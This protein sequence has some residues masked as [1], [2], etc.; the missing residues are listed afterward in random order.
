M[1]DQARS[2]PR[3]GAPF[4]ANNAWSGWGYEW[5][6]KTSV[7]G[8]PLVHVAV[9]RDAKGKL[10]VARGVVAIGQFAIGIITLAQFGVGLLFGL[11]QFTAGVVTVG[12]FALGGLFGLGQFATGYLAIGQ[13]ALGYCILA[14]TGFG[15]LRWTQTVKDPGALEYFIRIFGRIW[16]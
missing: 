2:C 13:F 10:R 7:M 3:C 4:P 11:G 5:R 8:W 9:G 12:Q 15:E 1:S 16:Q 6:S 14:Q